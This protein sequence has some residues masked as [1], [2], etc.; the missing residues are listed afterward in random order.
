MENTSY[1]GRQRNIITL[2]GHVHLSATTLTP[3]VGGGAC[4]THAEQAGGYPSRRLR[5]P[6]CEFRCHYPPRHNLFS[7]LPGNFEAIKSKENCD[8]TGCVSLG[9]MLSV[10]MTLNWQQ[11]EPWPKFALRLL[12]L[13]FN[14]GFSWRKFREVFLS[15]PHFSGE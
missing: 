6:K 1:W 9:K 8:L 10:Y 14:V 11:R 5:P 4:E 12:R 2:W 7:L 3:L 13:A 15:G